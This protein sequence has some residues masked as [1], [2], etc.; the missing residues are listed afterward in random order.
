VVGSCW[1]QKEVTL[2]L[3]VDYRKLTK[4]NWTEGST[5][6]C[7][8]HGI[9]HRRQIRTTFCRPCRFDFLQVPE[10]TITQDELIPIHWGRDAECKNVFEDCPVILLAWQGYAHID[11][12]RRA[13]CVILFRTGI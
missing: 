3:N 4:A 10:D 7:L 6:T 9:Q 12:L 1:R 8:S 11:V 13:K 2:G 5:E